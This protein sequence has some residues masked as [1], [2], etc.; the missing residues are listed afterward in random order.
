MVSSF[1]L[2]PFFVKLFTVSSAGTYLRY[3]IILFLVRQMKRLSDYQEYQEHNTFHFDEWRF[4]AKLGKSNSPT[5]SSQAGLE[6]W[7]SEYWITEFCV[8]WTK[9]N[10]YDVYSSNYILWCF[11]QMKAL[12]MF[13][14]EYPRDLLFLNSLVSENYTVSVKYLIIYLNFIWETLYVIHIS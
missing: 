9:L 12:D 7:K 8:W 11:M 5:F 1:S 10:F 13:H 2:F 6:R 3:V 4:A 14:F